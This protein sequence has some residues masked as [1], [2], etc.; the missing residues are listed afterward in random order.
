MTGAVALAGAVLALVFLPSRSRDEEPIA[1][2][3]EREPLGP[4][5][6]PVVERIES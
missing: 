3:L 5:L 1:I 2:T 4:R 6:E